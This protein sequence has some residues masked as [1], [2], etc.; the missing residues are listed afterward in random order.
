VDYLTYGIDEN[1]PLVHFRYLE[2]AG[3]F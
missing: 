1:K 3:S 2:I